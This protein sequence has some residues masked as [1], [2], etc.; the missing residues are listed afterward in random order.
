MPHVTSPEIARLIDQGCDFAQSGDHVQAIKLFR[1]AIARGETWVGLNLGNSYLAL[2]DP[3]SARAAFESAWHAGGDD[4][5]GFN[6]AC[7]IENEGDLGQ[8]RLV[9]K[10]LIQNGYTKAMV[11][12]ARQLRDEGDLNEAEALLARAM[13]ESSPV[14]DLAAGML[15]DLRW[16]G[17]GIIEPLL[18]RG[19]DVFPPARADLGE[20]LVANDQLDEGLR[21]LREGAAADEVESMLPLANRLAETGDK[22]GAADIYRHGFAL[23]DAHAATNLGVMLWADGHRKS[24]RKWIRRGAQRGDDRAQAWI[25]ANPE[26]TGHE[27]TN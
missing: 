27:R 8:A 18:R 4:D 7:L 20:L 19:A 2:N 11:E 23:G 5:A 1:K 6:L 25:D 14:G 24:A 9:Y 22:K 16:A 10:R 17:R 3:G 12:E 13:E 21:V 15:G 26:V